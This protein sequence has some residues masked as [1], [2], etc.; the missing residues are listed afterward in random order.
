MSYNHKI[1]SKNINFESKT[2]SRNRLRIPVAGTRHSN[3]KPGDRVTVQQ[4]GIMLYVTKNPKGCYKVERDGAIR[5]PANKYGL[6]YD[7]IYT[8]CD[9]VKGKITIF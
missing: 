3:I 7:Q 5:F 6:A 9:S 8:C 1:N 2:G 4:E